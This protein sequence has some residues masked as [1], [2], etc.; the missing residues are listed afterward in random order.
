MNS[1]NSFFFS[2]YNNRIISN[3]N[4][5]QTNKNTQVKIAVFCLINRVCTN[6]MVV[7]VSNAT[8][9]IQSSMMVKWFNKC[10][11]N[12]NERKTCH[13]TPSTPPLHF[14]ENPC[15]CV[16]YSSTRFL[17][18]ITTIFNFGSGAS[19]YWA[20]IFLYFFFSSLLFYIYCYKYIKVERKYEE[21]QITLEYFIWSHVSS[22]VWL[23]SIFTFVCRAQTRI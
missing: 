2:L 21:K 16:S 19:K 15:E 14:I 8:D 18:S 22:S 4:R 5:S 6:L 3:W 20:F 11:S 17:L 23:L 9:K 12:N 7:N 10:G 13:F 1:F